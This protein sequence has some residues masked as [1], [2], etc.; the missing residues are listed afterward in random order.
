M[1]DKK[2]YK[3]ITTEDG[4]PTLSL[5]KGESMHSLEGA[6]SESLYI[7]GFCIEKSM[8]F[9]GQ[10]QRAL[11][12]DHIESNPICHET[13]NTD[14]NYRKTPRK[15]CLEKPRIL[16]MGLGLGYNELIAHGLLLKTKTSHFSLISLLKKSRNWF[17]PLSPGLKNETSPLLHSFQKK[18]QKRKISLNQY[19]DQILKRVSKHFNETPEKIK[20]FCHQNLKRGS[21][22]ILGSLPEKKSL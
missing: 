22:Q 21:F 16:S 13:K 4:S 12:D 6:F 17:N 20:K 14:S 3:I 5:E 8:E 18:D 1:N 15:P 19:Y 7:Y 2:I 11:P 9:H 10:A